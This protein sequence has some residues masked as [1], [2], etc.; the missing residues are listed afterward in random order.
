V[1]CRVRKG[2]DDGDG[3]VRN[4][5]EGRKYGPR[6]AFPAEQ[7]MYGEHRRKGER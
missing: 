4:E 1:E 2:S 3:E 5:I 7:P 6:S